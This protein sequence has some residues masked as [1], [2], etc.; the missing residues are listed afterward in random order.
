MMG[1]LA[2]YVSAAYTTDFQPMGANMGL[3]P[4]L[5]Q[6]IRGKQERYLMMAEK[7]M[8]TLDHACKEME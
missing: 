6:K 1:A 5:E 4:P 2:D 7:A 3:L 8:Q